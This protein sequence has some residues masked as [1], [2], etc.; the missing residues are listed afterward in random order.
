MSYKN[1]M[2]LLNEK[3]PHEVWNELI[4]YNSHPHLHI[5]RSMEELAD[6]ALGEN[7]KAVSTFNS[8]AQAVYATY[9]AILCNLDK[10][11]EIFENYNK[12]GSRVNLTTILYDGFEEDY[13]ISRTF[14]GVCYN[15]SLKIK[16][17]NKINV[18][19]EK[20]QN[21]KY[22][23]KIIT[24][25]PDFNQEMNSENTNPGHIKLENEND[26]EK[27]KIRDTNI[28]LDITKMKAYLYG[29][30]LK[31]SY[32]KC[33]TNFDKSYIFGDSIVVQENKDNGDIHRMFINENKINFRIYGNE[34]LAKKRYISNR[35]IR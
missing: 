30:N 19:I 12:N 14:N 11:K 20:D 26:R 23:I 35:N 8:E 34:P 6:R 5:A 10:F 28:K 29:D 18:I 32:V 13:G 1:F 27:P 7:K 2:K 25:Y 33:L 16:E 9:D 22:G 3:D 15:D 17:T 24:C 4:S 21:T 31:K